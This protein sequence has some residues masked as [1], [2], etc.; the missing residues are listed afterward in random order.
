MI[1]LSANAKKLLKHF[2]DKGL[3]Q[4]EYEYPAE[5]EKLF[6]KV[7]DCEDAQAELVDAQLLELGS[8]RS[9]YETSKVRA[10]AL[11]LDGVR[12]LDQNKL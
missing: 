11:T 1:A 10:A 6:P 7:E 4:Q 2:K 9:P 5:Q 12:Y 3:E 8:A